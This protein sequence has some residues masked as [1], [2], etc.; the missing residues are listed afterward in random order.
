MKRWLIAILLVV[1]LTAGGWV[2]GSPHYTLWQMKRAAEARDTEALASHVDFPAV[3]ENVKSQLS[4]RMQGEGG[5][6]LGALVRAGIGNAV[7]DAAVSPEG[8]RFIF[9][10]APLAES[11]SER[12]TPIR[13]KANEMAYQRVA[14]DRFRLTRR[15]GAAL[16]FRLQGASWKLVGVTLPPDLPH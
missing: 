6:I 3:R 4:T 11:E 7:V 12:P 2:W 5:G 16:E 10:A 14:L 9:A 1:L 15:D 13:L 8:M